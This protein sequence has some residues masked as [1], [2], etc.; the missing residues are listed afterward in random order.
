MGYL[1]SQQPPCQGAPP[2]PSCTGERVWHGF[3]HV[4]PYMHCYGPF[5]RIVSNNLVLGR[6]SWKFQGFQ[7]SMS[8]WPDYL[9]LWTILGV[10][11]HLNQDSKLLPNYTNSFYFSK[12]LELHLYLSRT[13]LPLRIAE[14]DTYCWTFSALSSDWISCIPG[15]QIFLNL[16]S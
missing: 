16:G 3:S 1:R 10:P 15:I 14:V 2:I 4:R 11:V 12:L 7:A 9:L 13:R 6:S 8:P 5:I